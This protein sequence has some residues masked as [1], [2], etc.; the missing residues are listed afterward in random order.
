MSP[1]LPVGILLQ[2]LRYLTNVCMLQL[3]HLCDKVRLSAFSV[4]V[5]P[6]YVAAV[7][8]ADEMQNLWC[9]L[10]PGFPAAWLRG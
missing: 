1:A 5:W 2:I 4:E 9:F 8:H 7:Q 6:T 3:V 10:I